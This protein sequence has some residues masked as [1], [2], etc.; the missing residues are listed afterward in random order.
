MITQIA[1]YSIAVIS[2]SWFVYALTLFLI[3]ARVPRLV[4]DALY[5][6]S[7]CSLYRTGQRIIKENR[8]AQQRA[9]S[10]FGR[11]SKQVYQTYNNLVRQA[12]RL[13]VQ[14]IGDS[15][16]Q[17]N[18]TTQY[19]AFNN[20]IPV[21][22]LIQDMLNLDTQLTIADLLDNLYEDKIRMY[23]CIYNISYNLALIFG[24]Q[25]DIVFN[26][27]TLSNKLQHTI[28]LSSTTT[29]EVILQYIV[30]QVAVK[31]QRI[32]SGKVSFYDEAS[33]SDIYGILE[34]IFQ[35]FIKFKARGYQ[36]RILKLVV[37]NQITSARY[38]AVQ[39][40]AIKNSLPYD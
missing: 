9:Y 3:I 10:N 6:L 23:N 40:E 8:L 5:A 14:T 35:Y 21:T 11:I 18:I 33:I 2:L 13:G 36:S 26:N 15:I 1:V 7:L 28:D 17:L 16:Q 12:Y 22:S 32:F 27:W 30:E 20:R 4:V 34:D 19:I 25:L 31:A 24:E 38:R 39:S 29:K 37:S